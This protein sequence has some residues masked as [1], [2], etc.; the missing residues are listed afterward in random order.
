MVYK[1]LQHYLCMITHL[2]LITDILFTAHGRMKLAENLEHNIRVFAVGALINGMG[3]VY[4]KNM[5]L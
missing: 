4:D 3:T 1:C 5:T 2:I